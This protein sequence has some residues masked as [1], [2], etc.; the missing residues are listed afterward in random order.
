MG[1]TLVFSFYLKIPNNFCLLEEY[2]RKRREENLGVM[3]ALALRGQEGEWL[4]AQ[5]DAWL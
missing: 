4:R 3:G 1:F 2:A 5:E